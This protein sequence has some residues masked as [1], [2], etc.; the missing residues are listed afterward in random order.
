MTI[1]SV[2]RTLSY[3]TT[4]AYATIKSTD[5]VERAYKVVSRAAA[6]SKARIAAQAKIAV[7][8]L[9]ASQNK[10]SSIL[11]QAESMKKTLFVLGGLVLAG[12]VF[13]SMSD[14]D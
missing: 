14:N 2:L 12:G 4:D 6:T 13:I 10:A 5:L 1:K 3:K 7:E 8:T 11:E 9:Q